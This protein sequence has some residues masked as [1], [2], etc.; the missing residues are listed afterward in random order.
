MHERVN[1]KFSRVA[2][3]RDWLQRA[4]AKERP[5]S[6]ELVDAVSQKLA[7][8]PVT[9]TDPTRA[10]KVALMQLGQPKYLH[11]VPQLLYRCLGVIPLS[12]D[13]AL[14]R[15]LVARFEQLSQTL[16][17]KEPFPISYELL[18]AK[19]LLTCSVDPAIVAR[20]SGGFC[21]AKLL[22]FER[23]VAPA[24]R[25]LGWRNDPLPGVKWSAL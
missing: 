6:P 10:V 14:E 22:A 4:Q 16:R 24:F 20:F 13:P 8:L 9:K 25:A 17:L 1:F 3:F 7:T 11:S 19:L 12:L 2:H 18:M 5:L 15:G 21:L 23:R